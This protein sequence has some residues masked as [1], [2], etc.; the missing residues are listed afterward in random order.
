MG[1]VDKGAFKTLTM[2]KGLFVHIIATI[3]YIILA[4]YIIQ[5]EKTNIGLRLLL[6]ILYLFSQLI[7]ATF[8]ET[9]DLYNQKF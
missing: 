7:T 3:I 8:C 4:L 1:Y 5:E 2:N 9:N 6:V